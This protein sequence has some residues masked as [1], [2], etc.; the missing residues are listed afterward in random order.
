MMHRSK[1]LLLGWTMT[2]SN[3]VS[4]LAASGE[5]GFAEDAMR[6]FKTTGFSVLVFAVVFLI[7]WKKL[8]PPIVAALDKRE[9]TIRDSLEAAERARADAQ[10]LMAEHEE[11]LEKSRAEARAIIDEG[12]ADA[13]RVKENIIAS[14]RKDAE[15]ISARARREIELAK[16]AAVDGL[17]RQAAALSFEIAEKVIQKSL[18]PEDHQTMIDTC[19]QRYKQEV[20]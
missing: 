10:K 1:C 3:S 16:K 19:I 8:F 15:E 9:R 12:K 11:S 6:I 4:L 5:G 14:A 18:R 2:F 20:A 13:L 7:L 17:Y